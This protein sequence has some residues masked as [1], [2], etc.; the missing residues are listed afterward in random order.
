LFIRL[1]LQVGRATGSDMRMTGV[2]A[3]PHRTG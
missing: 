3:V 1:I 2:S